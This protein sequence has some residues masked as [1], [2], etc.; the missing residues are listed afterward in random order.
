MQCGFVPHG[1]CVGAAGDGAVVCELV[2]AAFNGVPPLVESR[3]EHGRAISGRSAGTA[4][5][6][7]VCRDRDRGRDPAPARVTPI[8]HGRAGL[9][10]QYPL[11]ARA[12]A[13]ASD[14]GDLDGLQQRDHLEAVTSL[15]GR[16]QQRQRFPALFAGQVDRRG[17][18]APTTP[19]RV[20]IGFVA[21][22]FDLGIGSMA[23]S[24]G[25]LMSPVDRGIY[26]HL[27]GDHACCLD[28][29]LQLRP[30]P[31]PEAARCHRRNK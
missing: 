10:G 22:W 15:T 25:V 18:P 11:R 6:G 20:I 27:P 19:Q 4:A 29:C 30:D 26:R 5:G 23:G 31:G 1:E 9:V 2:D 3:A 24:G 12:C 14:P 17:H 21:G 13:A 7:L 16:E 28:P 8:G